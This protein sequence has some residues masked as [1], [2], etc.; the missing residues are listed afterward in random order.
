MLAGGAMPNAGRCSA[1]ELRVGGSAGSANV[2]GRERTNAK[3]RVSPRLSISIILPGARA[4]TTID[5]GV[6]ADKG[7]LISVCSISRTTDRGR[8]LCDQRG[9]RFLFGQR[10]SMCRKPVSPVRCG[11]P[12]PPANL[13]RILITPPL[14]P[15]FFQKNEYLPDAGPFAV[16]QDAHT[17]NLR[18]NPSTRQD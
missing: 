14:G 12:C 2:V 18:R 5:G 9:K 17:I 6:K 3:E 13:I 8:N 11:N 16:H 7:S 10:A 4:S 15:P 1:R